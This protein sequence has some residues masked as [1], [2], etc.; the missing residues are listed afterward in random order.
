MSDRYFL[1]D[2]MEPNRIPLTPD[3]QAC[4]DAVRAKRQRI[5]AKRAGLPD[6]APAQAGRMPDTQLERAL[7]G[8]PRRYRDQVLAEHRDAAEI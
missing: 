3:Q 6:P 4:A 7:A 2:P 5:R 1:L 8:L